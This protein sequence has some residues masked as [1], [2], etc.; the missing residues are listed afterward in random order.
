[1]NDKDLFETK[2][3]GYKVENGKLVFFSNMLDGYRH[4]YKDLQ[5]ICEEMNG[6]LKKYDGYEERLVFLEGKAIPQKVT[7]E[8]T[9]FADTTCPNCKNVVGGKEKWGESWVK[10]QEEYCKFCGQRLNWEN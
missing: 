1:M 5:E 6:L 3:R 10:V 2:A 9:V 8:A 7:H 4:E